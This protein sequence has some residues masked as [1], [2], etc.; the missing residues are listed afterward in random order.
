MTAPGCSIPECFRP[1]RRRGL[2]EMH[3]QR[4]Y[5]HGDPLVRLPPAPGFRNL[6]QQRQ[7]EMR[8]KSGVK[9]AAAQECSRAASGWWLRWLLQAVRRETA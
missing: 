6:S 8:H 3:Y 2:C 4:W 9:G 1:P 5:R 7:A